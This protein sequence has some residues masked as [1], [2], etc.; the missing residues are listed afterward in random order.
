MKL[1][2][3]VLILIFLLA[4]V[5][6]FYNIS[7]NPPGLYIDEVSIGNNAYSILKTG[8]DEYGQSFPLFFRSFGDYKMP[9]YIYSVAFSM[10]IFGKNELAVRFPSA[11]AGTLTIIVLYFLL[12]ELLQLHIDVLFRKKF[13]YLP[14]LSALLIA[15]SPWHIQFSRAGFEA[16]VALFIFL[17]ACLSIVSYLKKRETRY[18]VI[19]Y[20]LLVCTIYTYHTFRIASPL[21]MG[22][23][24]VA[25]F[26]K[27]SKE[28]VKLIL[29]GAVCLLLMFPVLQFSLT[30]NGVERFS[31]TSAFVEY[32]AKTLFNKILIYPAV[33]IKNYFSYFSLE[34]LFN[35]GDGIGRHQMSGSGIL[36][37]WQLP[38]IIA[39]LYCLLREKRS[40]LRYFILGILVL[41][42]LPASIARPSPHTLR[43]LLSVV[44]FVALSSMGIIILLSRIRKLRK[45]FISLL[46]IVVAYYSL[47]YLH[48]YYA[49]YPKVNILDWDGG[50]KQAVEAL[51][52]YDQNKYKIVIDENIGSLI[53]YYHFYGYDSSPEPEIVKSDWA[54]PKL[55]GRKQVIYVRPYYGAKNAARIVEN[56]IL[57]NLNH[58]IAFQFWE[59]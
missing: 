35:S 20:I 15:I 6:R 1:Y 48:F 28:R 51:S 18:L 14:I 39:G 59:Y 7:N 38:F 24:G 4:G 56:I 12:K 5:L 21:V 50:S 13:K 43:N 58:D 57:P 41:S 3:Y 8:K 29:L 36:F 17:L 27:M 11:L 45:L 49:H 53:S 34:Y 26:W 23:L 44:P 46:V 52:K 40:Y 9:A 19:G 31:Q 22:I 10:S 25:I 54:K 33:F 30:Q 47:S 16:N 37:L 32:P 55:W 42:P 2:K